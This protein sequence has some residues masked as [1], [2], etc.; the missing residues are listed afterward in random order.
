MNTADTVDAQVNQLAVMLLA[1]GGPMALAPFQQTSR[2]ERM[3]SEL[4]YAIRHTSGADMA[5]L[6]R[7]LAS[8][9]GSALFRRVTGLAGLAEG[10]VKGSAKELVNMVK[11]YSD[12]RLT[13]HLGGRVGTASGITAQAVSNGAKSISSL[14]RELLANPADA[15]PKLLV[16]V[17]S[18]VATSG[19]IDGN[20]GAPDL[21]IPLMGIG[22]HRSPF[23]H[24][25]LIG[26]LLEV[27]LLLLTRI[28]LCTHKNLPSHHDPLWEGIARKSVDILSSAGKGASIGIAY[29]LMVDAVVQPG[30]YHGMPFDMP[31]E[32]HQTIFAANAVAEASSVRTYPTEEELTATPEQLAQ[33]KKYRLVRISIA[34]ALLEFL[35][36][37]NSTVLSNY[38][39]WLQA[40][41]KRTISPT[42]IAQVQFLMVADGIRRPDTE[43]ER[44]WVAWVNAKR[45]AGWIT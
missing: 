18:S 40:L 16:L 5:S 8:D 45:R 43:H 1:L 15:G 33:H 2:F 17:L 32:A 27:A 25:I 24:S 28:V 36:P 21:D 23:T 13:E 39:A 11:A 31:M 14:T 3:A 29:H 44:A 34:P 30:A 22:E 19:G 9:S 12:E 41:A 4:E 10:L 37:S 26:S 20:G 38:G 35:S 7:Y 42:T 6:L